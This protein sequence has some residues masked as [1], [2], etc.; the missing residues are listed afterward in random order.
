MPLTVYLRAI[1]S[2]GASLKTKSYFEYS[3]ESPRKFMYSEKLTGD[4]DMLANFKRRKFIF[5]R[6]CER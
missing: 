2:E 4:G 1:H 6:Y 5:N 3:L